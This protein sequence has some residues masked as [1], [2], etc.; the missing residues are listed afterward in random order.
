MTKMRA[1]RILINDY[2]HINTG[3]ALKCL[4][5]RTKILCKEDTETIL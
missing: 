4:K 2:S 1:K 3:F 5:V